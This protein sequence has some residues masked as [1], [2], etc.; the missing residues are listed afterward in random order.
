MDYLCVAGYGIY[1]WV[2]KTDAWQSSKAGHIAM[3]EHGGGHGH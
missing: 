2:K 3:M 1:A